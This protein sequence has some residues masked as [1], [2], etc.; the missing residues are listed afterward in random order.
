MVLFLPAWRDSVHDRQ[1]LWRA[2]HLTIAP[3]RNGSQ[4]L[5]KQYYHEEGGHLAEITRNAM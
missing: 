5:L 1:A 4:S 3:L 2:A